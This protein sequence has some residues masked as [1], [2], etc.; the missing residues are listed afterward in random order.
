[1]LSAKT[2]QNR[3]KN[4]SECSNCFHSILRR[5]FFRSAN[6]WS[7]LSRDNRETRRKSTVGAAEQRTRC[8]FSLFREVDEIK[9]KKKT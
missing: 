9:E 8:F 1:M 5:L 4:K 6:F 7:F 2:D 3:I